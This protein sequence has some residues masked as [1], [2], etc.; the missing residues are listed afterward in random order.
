MLLQKLIKRFKL[1]WIYIITA[2]SLP[3]SY[4]LSLNCNFLCFSCPLSGLCI[5]FYPIIIL[6]IIFVKL[7]RK[8]KNFKNIEKS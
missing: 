8:I 7:I 3:F 6:A 4:I 5:I 2:S 1:L